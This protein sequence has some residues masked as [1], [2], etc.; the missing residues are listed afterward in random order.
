MTGHVEKEATML[1]VTG[2]IHLAPPDVEEFVADM[3]TFARTT[4]AREG[5]LFYAVAPDDPGSGRMLVVER[6]R[7]QAALDA[8]LA[9]GDT[10]AFVERWQGRMTSDLAKF[11]AGNERALTAA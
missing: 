1:I 2:Y 3:A 6:W 10:A 9:A 11:D 5:C 8:H 7:D 4:R